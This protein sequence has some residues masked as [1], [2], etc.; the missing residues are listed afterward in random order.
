MRNAQ[1]SDGELYDH[2]SEPPGDTPA[3]PAPGEAARAEAEQQRRSLLIPMPS[4]A[5]EGDSFFADD[6]IPHYAAREE[7]PDEVARAP[8]D[9]RRLRAA[10]SLAA[11]VAIGAAAAV[12]HVHALR[13]AGTEQ[14]QTHALAQRL[15]AM[16]AK[17]ESL[18]AGRS[19]DEVASLRK[20][21]AEIKSSAANTR[22]LGGAVS[23]LASRVDRLEKDQGARLD[24]LGDRIDHSATARLADIAARLDKLEA[25]AAPKPVVAKADPGVSY[26]TTGAI[27]RP[28]PPR[29]RGYWLAAIRNG[30][31]MI[32]GPMGEFAVGPGDIVPG[33]GGRVLRIERRGRDW[34]VVT[35][36]G[37][38][39]AWD[40]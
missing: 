14:A 25:K 30:Y 23:V 8:R 3:L 37:Q 9:W 36:R 34:A 27:N 7:G 12:E 11:V 21:L 38:I 24:K 39:V 15:D 32:D 10:A 5:A 4:A 26:E 33:G 35:T 19:R 16:S 40:D 18:Q 1:R 6:A 2:D 17:L 20:V 29:L 28:T 13:T 31:A 22:D